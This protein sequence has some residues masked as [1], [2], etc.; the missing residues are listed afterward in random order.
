VLRQQSQQ[1]QQLW[2]P[3]QAQASP[4]VLQPVLQQGLVRRPRQPL[5]EAVRRQPVLG[6]LVPPRGWQWE[7][8]PTTF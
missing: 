2:P 6:R 3:L 1:V 8:R 7:V 4:P 5:L